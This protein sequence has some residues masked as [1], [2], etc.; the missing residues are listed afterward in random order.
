MSRLGKQPITIPSGVTATYADGVFAV[1]GP[2]GELTRALND[3][4]IKI[5]VTDDAVTV[6]PRHTR[7]NEAQAL[8]GTYAAHI[9][10]MLIGVTEGFTKVL[11][12]EGVGYRAEVQGDT[13]TLSVGYS[14]P[15]TFTI[16]EG[17]TVNVE[18]NTITISGTDKEQLGQFAAN[19]RATRPPEPYKGKGIHYQGEYIIR[20]Q[21]K[22]AV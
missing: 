1:T 21:G 15:V 18:K 4:S 11:E 9:R 10:N 22:K 17:L 14:H 20:K 16:P 13:L 12:I 3:R 8:W 19:V 6:T 7:D 2:K 5:D